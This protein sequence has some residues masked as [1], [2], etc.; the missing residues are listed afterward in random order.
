MTDG[1][2]DKPIAGAT[3]DIARRAG[4]FLLGALALTAVVLLKDVLAGREPA[5]AWYALPAAVG[6][7]C[8]LAVRYWRC[9]VLDSTAQ[10]RTSEQRLRLI[11]EHSSDGINMAEFDPRTRTRRLIWCNDQYVRMS[12]R[13]RAEL[14]AADDLNAFV[15][16]PDAAENLPRWRQTMQAGRPYSGRASWNRPDG[17]ANCYEWT[18]APVAVG[19]K[20]LL[21]GVDRDITARTE[22]EQ[23][24]SRLQDEVAHAARIGTIGEV[25]AELA[26]ELNQPLSSIAN[27]AGGSARRLRSEAIVP[28]ELA[29]ILEQIA[30]QA[31]HAGEIVHRVADLVRRGEPRRAAVAVDDILRQVLV[32]VEFEVRRHGSAVRLDLGR[33]LPPIMADRVQLQQVV[34]NLVY[35][36]CEALQTAGREGQIVI[37]TAS[38]D[39]HHVAVSVT[40]TGSGIDPE[41]A[42]RLFEP[43][44]TTK[45][46]GM[47]LGLAISRSI[48]EAHGGRLRYEADAA[49]GT[50]FAF[51][52]PVAEEPGNGRT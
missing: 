7:V 1:T 20:V 8:G 5:S 27:Y 47:G 36:A 28:A 30:A 12:G 23:R 45:A 32:L 35:N 6:G 51:T 9:R 2:D 40:D 39:A 46:K 15:S 41:T 13:S 31:V 42:D 10:L 48:V 16:Y 18:A 11:L 38:A 52:V 49:G 44:Y 25:A 22:A 29:A 33:D 19:D 4:W 50:T 17:Q 26:H 3:A 34:L 37:R 43:F 21:I 24:I 14:M